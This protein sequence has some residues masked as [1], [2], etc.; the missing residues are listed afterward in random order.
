MKLYE[1]KFEYL[2]HQCR[3]APEFLEELP[4]YNENFQYETASGITLNP[5]N[6]V[7]DLGIIVST[8][9]K[10]DIQI[11]T[12]IQKAKT[13]SAWVFNVFKCRD[14]VTMLTLY[15]SLVRSI[16]EYCCPLWHPTK[17][18]LTKQIEALQRSFTSRI[19]GCQNKDYWERLSY[20]KLMSLQRRRERY[21]IITMW[22][23]LNGF[24]P[25]NIN[26][27]FA[28]SKRNGTIAKLP[29]LSKSSSMKH[30]SIYDSSF[31]VLGPKLWNLIPANITLLTDLQAFKTRLYDEFLSKIPDRPPVTGYVC[32]NNNSLVEWC[33]NGT[34]LSGQKC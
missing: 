20:L 24:H 17:L 12:M 5:S 23:V 30:Q 19:H 33:S 21:I 13:M 29:T 15:K 9:L 16:V 14:T 31:A 7:K 1:D 6:Y 28:D 27:V 10:W 8:D 18:G 4:H 22:K 2:S 32:A 3:S 25:N 26:I 34:S 11:N